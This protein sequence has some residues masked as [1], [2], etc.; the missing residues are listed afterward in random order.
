MD[1]AMRRRFAFRELHP[2]HE[3]VSGVLSAWLKAHQHNKLGQEPAALLNQLNKKIKDPAFSIGPSYLMPKRGELTHEV[4]DRIWSSEI[5][6]LLEE[7]HYGEGKD[8]LK[9]YR[10]ETLQAERSSLENAVPKDTTGESTA[11][12]EAE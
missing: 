1:A 11:P 6:P 7:H 8:V 4:L 3:P 9:Q 12:A 5:L 2:A 10:L